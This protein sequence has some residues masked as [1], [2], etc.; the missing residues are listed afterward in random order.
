MTGTPSLAPD[1]AYYAILLAAGASSRFD[2]SKLTASWNDGVLLHAALRSARAAPVARVVVVTGAH[3]KEV[4][5][6]VAEA[7]STQ[8]PPVTITHCADHA[9]GMSASLRCGLSALPQDTA[10][11]FIFLGDMPFVPTGLPDRLLAAFRDGARAA[12]PV[13]GDRLGHPVL[14]SRAAFDEFAGQAGDGAGGRAL[15]AMGDALA[16]VDIADAGIF[17]DIDT[18]AEMAAAKV[19]AGLG[20]T[21]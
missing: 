1:G 16:R 15:R 18:R 10:G 11:A 7:A 5:R 6:V 13:V 12:V 20:A 9:C 3:A 17:T 2:G 19:A 21:S 8:G 4:E 14:I